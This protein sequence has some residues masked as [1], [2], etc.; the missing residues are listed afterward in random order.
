MAFVDDPIRT[1]YQYDNYLEDL[2]K[3][4]KKDQDFIKN[5]YKNNRD[6]YIT[7]IHNNIKNMLKRL[8]LVNFI[9]DYCESV[10]NDILIT[11]FF[12]I[13]YFF[14]NLSLLKIGYDYFSYFYFLLA[15]F[16]ILIIILNITKLKGFLIPIIIFIW[17]T[18]SINN[19]I[20]DIS[21]ENIYKSEYN[22]MIVDNNL[23]KTDFFIENIKQLNLLKQN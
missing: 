4:T 15:S 8:F 16:T 18:I 21:K 14:G 3:E 20:Y 7:N 23:S 11:I 5:Y 17:S 12:S 2:R 6:N 22:K 1:V 19:L 10:H 13:L 9:E